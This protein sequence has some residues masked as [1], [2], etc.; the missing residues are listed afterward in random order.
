MER[1]SQNKQLP[2]STFI[3]WILAIM[4]QILLIGVAYP[5]LISSATYELPIIGL[6]M[7]IVNFLIWSWYLLWH[8]KLPRR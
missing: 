6:V 2:F 8:K 5:F 4:V 7:I 3:V 1:Q